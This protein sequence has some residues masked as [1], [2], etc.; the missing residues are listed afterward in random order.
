MIR[1]GLRVSDALKLAFDCII[2]DGDGAPYLRYYN[3]KMRREALVPIDEELRGL[4]G[5][6]QRRS[7]PAFPTEPRSCS[8]ARSPTLRVE[9]RSARASIG[10]RS[11]AG[12]ASATSVT[13]VASPSIS[14]LISGG[15][16]WARP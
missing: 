7:S 3:H 8:P 11:I 15:T 16:R 1:C 13:N 5:D 6:Q 9:S 2:E 14:H 12:S 10:V 4:I